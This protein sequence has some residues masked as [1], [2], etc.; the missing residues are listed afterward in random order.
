[1]RGQ[2][3]VPCSSWLQLGHNKTTATSA[4]VRPRQFPALWEELCPAG[5]SPP[6]LFSAQNCF[7]SRSQV[8]GLHILAEGHCFDTL[9]TPSDLVRLL[10]GGF[11]YFFSLST[12]CF[13]RFT[14]QRQPDEGSPR[15]HKTLLA[16]NEQHFWRAPGRSCQLGRARARIKL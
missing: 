11:F 16:G 3:Q 13:S 8:S 15:E 6:A 12:T 1:M 9:Q 7:P 14:W 4:R 10:F 2:P 5:S